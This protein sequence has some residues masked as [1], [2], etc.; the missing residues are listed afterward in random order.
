MGEWV[1]AW[2][3]LGVWTGEGLAHDWHYFLLACHCVCDDLLLQRLFGLACCSIC[4]LLL[5]YCV[6]IELTQILAL[7]LNSF[8]LDVF[9][10]N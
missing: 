8:V 2:V 7:A 10:K 3:D 1:N 9:V 4:L 5:R 6:R